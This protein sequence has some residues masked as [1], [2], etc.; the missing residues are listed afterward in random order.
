MYDSAAGL[1]DETVRSWVHD[2]I[3]G[4]YGFLHLVFGSVITAWDKLVHAGYLVWVTLDNFVTEAV[5]AI[6]HILKTV[7]PN[8]LKFLSGLIAKVEQYAK[9]VYN[10]AVR[11]LNA[12]RQFVLNL[13]A[14]LTTWV[15][16][17]IYNPLKAAFDLAWH[18]IS[19]EGATVWHYI[20]NPADLVEL[21]WD[22]LINK[23]EAEAWNI[24]GKLGKF[25]LSL[26]THN[27]VR[28]A[29]LLEDIIDSIL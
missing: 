26:V 6:A 11:E 12:L 2:L 3:N 13:I 28:F 21:I 22:H 8:V 10:F 24:G 16:T 14:Q 23:L 1:I 4:L 18:W 25:F 27:L 20:S 19:H 15:T 9:D 5:A 7:I 29:T 17:H